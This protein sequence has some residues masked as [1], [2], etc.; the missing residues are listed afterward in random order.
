[1]A[2]IRGWVTARFLGI[3]SESQTGDKGGQISIGMVGKESNANFPYP[4][5]TTPWKRLDELPVVLESLCL[6]YMEVNT[7][8][9]LSPLVPYTRLR[10]LG[11]HV[12][13]PTL[14]DYESLCEPLADWVAT[15]EFPSEA[16]GIPTLKKYEQL[17]T[18]ESR[19]KALKLE[20]EKWQNAYTKQMKIYKENVG[21]SPA[22][23]SS[24]NMLFPGLIRMIQRA[25]GQMAIAAAAH[26]T[27]EDEDETDIG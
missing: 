9:D 22:E 2:M 20:I 12:S 25:L 24:P 21:L 15:G 19:L 10:N 18:P 8:N 17:D 27:D 14:F 26:E 3:L 6:A 23:M 4:L 1:M 13:G 16:L 11:T 7:R 5:L